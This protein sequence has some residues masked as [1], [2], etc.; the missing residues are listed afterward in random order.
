MFHQ[1]LASRAVPSDDVD[2]SVRQPSFLTKFSESQ[3]SQ[4]SEF[5]WLQHHGIPSGQGRSNL[6]RRH[7]QRKIP[8]NN[9]PHHATGFVLRTFVLKKL[10]PTRVVVE[11][12][13]YE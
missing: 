4:R 5:R 3:R 9:L 1:Q 7:E 12:P 6:P 8:G 2:D 10:C 13:R 11:M